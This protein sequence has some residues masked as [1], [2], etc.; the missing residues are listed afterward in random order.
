MILCIA[1]LVLLGDA[2]TRTFADSALPGQNALLLVV[3]RDGRL[4]AWKYADG[5]A[6]APLASPS[7]P[8]VPFVSAGMEGIVD[9]S[10][11][12]DAAS[13]RV[14]AQ[15]GTTVADLYVADTFTPANMGLVL[16]WPATKAPG[17]PGFLSDITV[18][19]LA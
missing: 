10:V 1:S 13:V 15:G 5:A 14:H 12:L 16:R 18:T 3:R 4:G 11:V 7:V 8:A 9:L 2:A 19:P 6:P 17:F